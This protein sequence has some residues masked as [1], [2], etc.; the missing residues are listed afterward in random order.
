MPSP[1]KRMSYLPDCAQ[2]IGLLDFRERVVGADGVIFFRK[3]ELARA[4]LDAVEPFEVVLDRENKSALLCGSG[5]KAV[6]DQVLFE[7]AEELRAGDEYVFDRFFVHGEEEHLLDV[8]LGA[9]N[10]LAAAHHVEGD[11]R[12]VER[13]G[14][15][16][17]GQDFPRLE[18]RGLEQ[19]LEKHGRR[20]QAG[21]AAPYL[22]VGPGVLDEFQVELLARP[23]DVGGL[24]DHDFFRKQRD[25]VFL[26]RL[27]RLVVGN[28][29]R[30]VF[31]VR[32]SLGDA[33]ALFDG[34]GVLA[35]LPRARS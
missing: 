11:V 1:E 31:A 27:D 4:L 3:S 2:F 26:D 5:G 32:R 22:F 21:V 12:H 17:F 6:A 20:G 16:P 23:E 15:L 34:P 24:P 7:L 35:A 28:V 25:D 30:L 29:N 9:R 33:V 19:G 14:F 8:L 18:P 13:S 10:V